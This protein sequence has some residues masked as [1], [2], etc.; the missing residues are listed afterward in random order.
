MLLAVGGRREDHLRT[1]AEVELVGRTPAVPYGMP[2]ESGVP[3]WILR[4][5]SR[6]LTAAF[7]E[8]RSFQ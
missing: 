4:R 8:A 3:L 5:P 1:Y 2:Y 6:P 7:E